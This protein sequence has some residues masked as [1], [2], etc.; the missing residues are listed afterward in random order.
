MTHAQEAQAFEEREHVD[1]RLG[2]KRGWHECAH[3]LAGEGGVD[4]A[5]EP[6]VGGR[7]INHAADYGRMALLKQSWFCLNKKVAKVEGLK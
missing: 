3:D 6:T 2:R 5:A 1:R 4:I 7:G